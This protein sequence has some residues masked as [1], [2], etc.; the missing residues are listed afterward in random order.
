MHVEVRIGDSVLMFADDFTAEFGLP[1][2]AEGR[3]PFHLHLYVPDADATW[4]QTPEELQ[5]RQAK[6]LAGGHP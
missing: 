1:P 6:A 3:L 4:N 5:E 2:L